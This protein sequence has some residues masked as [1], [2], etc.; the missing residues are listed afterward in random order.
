MF[1]SSMHDRDVASNLENE[2][3]I[4]AAHTEMY[5]A[6][7]DMLVFIAEHDRRAAYKIDGAR[8]ISDWV[9][10]RF[11]YTD[12]EAREIVATAKAVEFLPAIADSLRAGLL[13]PEK[14]RWLACFATIDEDVQLAHDAIGMSGAE[15][16]DMALERRRVTREWPTPGSSADT[17]A[18]GATSPTVSSTARSA[19]PTP[20]ARRC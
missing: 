5:R 13:T 15:V 11:G 8:T 6:F 2:D 1:V 3:A 14:V 9:A 16:R 4:V 12:R 17:C 19:C 18:C 7:A 10:Y 20:R